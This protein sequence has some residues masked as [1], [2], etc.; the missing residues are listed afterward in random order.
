M[1]VVRMWASKTSGR[2]LTNYFSSSRRLER[3][4]KPRVNHSRKLRACAELLHEHE[5]QKNRKANENKK[6]SDLDIKMSTSGEHEASTDGR[7]VVKHHFLCYFFV[8][9]KK[10]YMRSSGHAKYQN[11]RKMSS[12]WDCFM[13]MVSWNKP[14]R[15]AGVLDKF[16]VFLGFSLLWL[17]RCLLWSLMA[18]ILLMLALLINS[19][20]VH[21]FVVGSRL[22]LWLSSTCCFVRSLCTICDR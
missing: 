19:R 5:H 15:W 12:Q 22:Q 14:V 1:G 16:R 3:W 17:L 7:Y 6:K 9:S 13:R 4:W 8:M 18:S 20:K 11:N 2:Q 10:E 21:I